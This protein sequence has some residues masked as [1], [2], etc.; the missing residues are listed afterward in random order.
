[1]LGVSCCDRC[2]WGGSGGG[3]ARGNDGCEEGDCG[4]MSLDAHMCKFV[5]LQMHASTH[6]HSHRHRLREREGEEE[7]ERER[8]RDLVERDLVETE[9]ERA[10]KS[11]DSKGEKGKTKR[12]ERKTS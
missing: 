9:E 10:E 4:H 5:L 11:A 6:R 7:K 8:E 1:M 2:V 12:R 3:R